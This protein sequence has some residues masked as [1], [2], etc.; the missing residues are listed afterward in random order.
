[1]QNTPQLFLDITLVSV[2]VL[3]KGGKRIEE[4]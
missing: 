4:R 3:K 2:L 1:M